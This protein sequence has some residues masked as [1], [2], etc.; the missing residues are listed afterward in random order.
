MN[1]KLFIMDL[2]LPR[3][4]RFIANASLVKRAIAFIVDIFIVNLIIISPFKSILSSLI[5]SASFSGL[6]DYFIQNPDITS[7]I[8]FI[9]IIITM[10]VIL[11]F[12]LFEY[13]LNQTPGKIMMNLQ[14]HSL[15]KDLRFWQC[16][17]RSLFLIPFFPFMLLWVIDPIYT[18]FNKDNQRLTEKLSKTKVVETLY[19]MR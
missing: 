2:K 16:L 14:V 13:K 17:V 4:K 18:F 12:A 15:A 1:L 10:L 6:Q 19:L 8:Y 11:Y 9:T 3:Q 5:P 7:A